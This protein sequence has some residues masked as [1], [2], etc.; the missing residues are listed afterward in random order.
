M[1]CSSNS[2]ISV[3]LLKS[4]ACVSRCFLSM[5]ETIYQLYSR[6]FGHLGTNEYV[7][8]M[9]AGLHQSWCH[10]EDH[11]PLDTEGAGGCKTSFQRCLQETVGFWRVTTLYICGWYLIRFWAWLGLAQLEVARCNQ[12]FWFSGTFRFPLSDISFSLNCHL[13]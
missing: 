10:E 8:D 5:L 11:A 4:E 13:D 3:H 7:S 12:T 2:H 9:S 1:V 6:T